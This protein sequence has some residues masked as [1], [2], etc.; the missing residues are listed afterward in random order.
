[1]FIDIIYVY[2]HILE[3]MSSSCS[4]FRMAKQVTLT[5]EAIEL[6]SRRFAVLAEPMRLRLI[7]ALFEGEKNV[8]A[9]VD[10]VGGTQANVSRHLQSLTLAHILS[11][12]KKGLQVFYTIADPGIIKL[13]EIVC[14]S[15]QEQ[16]S[17]H[18]GALSSTTKR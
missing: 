8:N 5:P 16:F 17:K 2:K 13:C 11:R 4:I 10:E 18:A 12:R 14:G 9:L 3:Q 6:I 15:L 7:H 1:M